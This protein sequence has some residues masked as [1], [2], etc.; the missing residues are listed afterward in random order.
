MHC[1]CVNSVLLEQ[2]LPVAALQYDDL[3]GDFYIPG[4]VEAIG[5]KTLIQQVQAN[6][7][8][9]IIITAFW[10]RQDP[11]KLRKLLPVPLMLAPCNDWLVSADNTVAF[12]PIADEGC[13]ST[14]AD[15]PDKTVKTSRY[16]IRFCKN[17][18]LFLR[19]RSA[20]SI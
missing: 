8:N 16:T 19:H 5:L 4:F 20:L 11:E 17:C 18:F 1:L 10:D 14:L 2:P 9:Q 12:K 3:G 7:Q 13:A 15:T 6:G